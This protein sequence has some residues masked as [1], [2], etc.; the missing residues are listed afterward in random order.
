MWQLSLSVRNVQGA[1]PVPVLRW[2]ATT[3]RKMESLRDRIL[4]GCGTDEPWL[5]E[6]PAEYQANTGRTAVCAHFRKP[7]NVM[8]VAQM[9]PTPEVVARPGRA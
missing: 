3:W 1:P 6:N 7:L 5:T 2:S 9:A 4:H 8:E